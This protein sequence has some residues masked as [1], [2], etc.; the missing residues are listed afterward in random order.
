MEE[1]VEVFPHLKNVNKGIDIKSI[2]KAR[3]L[4]LRSNN[5]DDIHKAIKYG[6][7]TSTKSHNETIN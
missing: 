4:V 1:I 5:D 6:I 3:C 2:K 7:W